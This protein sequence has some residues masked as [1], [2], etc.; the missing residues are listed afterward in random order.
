[1]KKTFW[2]LCCLLLSTAASADAFTLLNR[3]TAKALVDPIRQGQPRLIA[4]WSSDCPHCKKNLAL[5]ARLSQQE[6]D[7]RLLTI[8]TEAPWDGLAEPLDRLQVPGLRYAYGD[9]VPEALA[10]AIDPTWRGELPRT[11][12]F[13]GRGQ[14]VALSGVVDEHKVRQLLKLKTK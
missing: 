10:Y 12:F 4:L 11:L 1:M 14:V 8:A 2:I 6:K 5:F 9:D 13:D 3:S 7:L